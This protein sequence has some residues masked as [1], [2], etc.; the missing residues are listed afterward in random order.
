[1][2]ARYYSVDDAHPPPFMRSI[3]RDFGNSTSS[4]ESNGVYGFS[5]NPLALG[6][7]RRDPF[8]QSCGLDGAWSPCSNVDPME[9]DKLAPFGRSDEHD[10]LDEA[11]FLS[12]ALAAEV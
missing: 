8:A 2:K 11:S 9:D 10:I 6:D 7:L 5:G 4:I 1:M 12:E 3:P